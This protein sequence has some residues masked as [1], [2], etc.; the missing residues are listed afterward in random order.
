MSASEKR[1]VAL[2]RGLG[3]VSVVTPVAIFIVLAAVF[4]GL[5]PGCAALAPQLLAL[6]LSVLGTLAGLVCAIVALR[7]SGSASI[8]GSIGLVLN[9]GYCLLLLFSVMGFF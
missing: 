3:L 6:A 5:P 1:E 7:K 9:G 4:A 2:A 8:L